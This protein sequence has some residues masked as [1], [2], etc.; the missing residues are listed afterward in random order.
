MARRMLSK[1]YMAKVYQNLTTCWLSK[2]YMVN[3]VRAGLTKVYMVNV[4][5]D[6]VTKVY[7]VNIVR[8]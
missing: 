8:M 7:M 6:W 5:G 3:M 4:V 2:A 1:L